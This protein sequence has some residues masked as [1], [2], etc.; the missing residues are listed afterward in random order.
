MNAYCSCGSGSD[1]SS[2]ECGRKMDTGS[3][4]VLAVDSK[5]HLK[6]IP[7]FGQRCQL[8]SL[9]LSPHRKWNCSL[10]NACWWKALWDRVVK[11][12][13]RDDE[14]LVLPF[15]SNAT[16][17]WE[18]NSTATC[19]LQLL[20]GSFWEGICPGFAPPQPPDWNCNWIW[21]CRPKLGQLPVRHSHWP[22]M[23][24]LYEYQSECL[25]Q[26]WI[27]ESDQS[28]GLITF[29]ADWMWWKVKVIEPVTL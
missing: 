24:I 19:H 8:I 23:T 5:G 14:R 15:V 29:I 26:F 2:A 12:V 11:G 1:H 13:E 21:P 20:Y 17:F 25:I 22:N 4:V 7:P 9:T 16:L 18:R 10:P 28:E 3:G 27:N 6:V